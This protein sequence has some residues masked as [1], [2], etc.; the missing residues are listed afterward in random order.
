M[1]HRDGT[2]VATSGLLL[3]LYDTQ[4]GGPIRGTSARPDLRMAAATVLPDW[5]RWVPDLEG[6][7][8]AGDWGVL[9]SMSSPFSTYSGWQDVFARGGRRSVE[10]VVVTFEKKEDLEVEVIPEPERE[11]VPAAEPPVE[12]ER[13]QE[14]VPA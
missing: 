2:G 8:A 14:P 10:E 7:A 5:T 11:L 6:C 3:S 12:P 13:E 4:L 9:W 1:R